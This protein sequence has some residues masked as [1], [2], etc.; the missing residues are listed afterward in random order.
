MLTPRPLALAPLL[1]TA[2]LLGGCSLLPADRAATPSAPAAAPAPEGTV[3]P[4]DEVTYL[5]Q[6]E[7]LLAATIVIT[8]YLLR[9]D[10]IRHD[11]GE[12]VE[13][14]RPLVSDELY[15]ATV[16]EATEWQHQGLRQTGNR[17]LEASKLNFTAQFGEDLSVDS[18]HCLWIGDIEFVSRSDEVVQ[19]FIDPPAMIVRAAV[20]FDGDSTGKIESLEQVAMVDSC[21][22]DAP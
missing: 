22:S 12:G 14:L 13:Q 21:Q 7:A 8:D 15:A 16:T 19:N 6:E 9:S 4:E 3:L 2:L 17:V 5:N 10:A 11:G 20:S 1:A 18:K